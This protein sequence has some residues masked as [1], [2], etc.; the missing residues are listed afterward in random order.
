QTLRATIQWSYDLLSPPEQELLRNLSVFAGGW[1]LEAATAV[2]GENPDEFEVLDA[3]ARLVDKSLG[4]VAVEGAG[5]RKS[6]YRFLETVR[7]YALEKLNEAGQGQGA[8][9]RHLGY[10]LDLASNAQLTGPQQIRWLTQLE[11]EH[12]NLLAAISW[13]LNM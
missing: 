6:R 13:C 3:L 9:D 4:V 12:E 1:T 7:Q 11:V 5:T 2:S 10:F 8:R